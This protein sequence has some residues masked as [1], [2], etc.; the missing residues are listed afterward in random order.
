MEHSTPAIPQFKD[1]SAPN[2]VP[3]PPSI[4]GW[5]WPEL[6]QK[7]VKNAEFIEEERA[8]RVQEITEEETQWSI[9]EE[10]SGTTISPT[11]AARIKSE[12]QGIVK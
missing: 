4:S 8:A 1:K 10:Y 11:E 12:V 7:W 2:A 9:R 6:L 3:K 5:V